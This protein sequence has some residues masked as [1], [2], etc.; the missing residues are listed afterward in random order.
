[1]SAHR[2]RG[3]GRGRGGNHNRDSK[4][5]GQ[6]VN[7]VWHCD[8]TPRQPAIHFETK[9]PGPNKGRWFRSC[10]KQHGERCGFFLWDSDAQPR[11]LAALSN[12]SRSEPDHVVPNAASRATPSTRH[13]S[14]PPPPHTAQNGP[15]EPSRK[16]PFAESSNFDDDYGFGQVDADFD[17]ELNQ[18]LTEVETPSKAVKTTAFATP[19]STRRKLPWQMDQPSTSSAYGLQTPQTERKTLIDPFA[20]KQPAQMGS[21]FTPSKLNEDDSDHTGAP[22]SSFETPTPSRFK[23]AEADTLV[24][25]VLILLQE[26][27]VYLSAQTQDD[28]RALLSKHAKSAEGYRRGRDVIR[29]TVKARDAKITELAYRVSTLEAELEAEKAMVQHL[30]WENQ[31]EVP[32]A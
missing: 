31:E 9:K 3:R 21:L 4:P 12:N 15:S 23:N 24:Q 10:Q 7:G 8:C 30:Q 6:F 22:S 5:R 1:M 29:T 11:E 19:A 20:S 28:L 13:Q 26:A 17:Q 32:D 18:V 27:H 14:P 2:G 16:R 25:D